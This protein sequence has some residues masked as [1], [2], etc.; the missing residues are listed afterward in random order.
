MGHGRG[1]RARARVI[2]LDIFHHP[3]PLG[4]GSWTRAVISQRLVALWEELAGQHAGEG[5]LC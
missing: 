1:H 3:G 2:D 4:F 5:T